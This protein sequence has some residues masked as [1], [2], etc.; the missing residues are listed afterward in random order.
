MDED[1]VL[2]N[3]KVKYT[4]KEYISLNKFQIQVLCR[5]MHVIIYGLV[6]LLFS[7]Y[8]Y[9]ESGFC[10]QNIL[11]IIFTALYTLFIY[12]YPILY[13][14]IR[15]SSKKNIDKLGMI[16]DFN[17]YDSYFKVNVENEEN[18]YDYYYI[19]LYKVYENKSHFYLYIDKGHAYIIP[20]KRI[21]GNISNFRMVL[22]KN[23]L[24]KYIRIV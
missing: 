22:R 8:L 5:N 18:S 4:K 3:F 19:N 6:F 20:K 10:I 13:A 7:I 2:F 21:T 23:V 16:V 24:K 17:I 14:N 11:C 9:K 1:R 15:Y 12:F